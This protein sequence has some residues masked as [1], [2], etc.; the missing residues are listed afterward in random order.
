MSLADAVFGYGG[1]IWMS[2]TNVP[3]VLLEPCINEMNS[4]PNVN[5]TTF[6]GYAV[7]AWSFEAHLPKEGG[8]LPRWEA[9][10]LDVLP[11]QH[12]ADAVE[13]LFDK[14]KKGDRSGL[15]QGCAFLFGGLSLC[16]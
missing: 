4:L 15:L 10:R 2:Q 6:A 16:C 14:W 5:V 7:H 8:N 9:H 3:V 12:A 1:F 11:G 13:G